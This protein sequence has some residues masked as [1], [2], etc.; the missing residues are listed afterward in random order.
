MSKQ[1]IIAA[2]SLCKTFRGPSRGIGRGRSELR[3]VDGVTLE[4]MQ[5]ETLGLVG[6]SGC[7]KSTLG[8]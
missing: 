5:G 6:E 8:R 4:V 7:G 1:P 2:E 3:A